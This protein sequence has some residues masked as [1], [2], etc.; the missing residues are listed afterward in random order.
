MKRLSEQ[1]WIWPAVVVG[2]L[3]FQIAV[4]SAMI[5]CAHMDPSQSIEPD[6]HGK[7]LGWDAQRRALRLSD[8]LNWQVEWSV[9]AAGGPLLDRSLRL[10]LRDAS[11]RPVAKASVEVVMFHHARASDRTRVTFVEQSPGQYTARAPMRRSGLWE[12]RF[13][14]EQ[15]DRLWLHTRQMQI[16][17]G[18]SR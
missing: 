14:A 15:G 9:G 12:F 7:A 4:C 2:L 1:P 16:A 6:F 17:E 5:Y 11:G 8:A 3:G 13:R 10:K 18:A